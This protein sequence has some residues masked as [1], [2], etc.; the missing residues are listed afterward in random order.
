MQVEKTVIPKNKSDKP[1]PDYG[2]VH[3]VD[4]SSAVKLVEDCESSDKR[5]EYPEGSGN[6][7]QV[8]YQHNHQ[9]VNQLLRAASYMYQ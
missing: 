6:I 8:S 9:L 5:L 1:F 2:F 7:L 3:F 4:R